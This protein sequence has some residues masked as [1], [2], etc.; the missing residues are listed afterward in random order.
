MAAVI[1]HGWPASGCGDDG[2]ARTFGG[3]GLR[4]RRLVWL[5]SWVLWEGH[6][7]SAEY[8]VWCVVR[9]VGG[10]WAVATAVGVEARGRCRY[11]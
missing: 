9:F 11:E 2:G 5:L 10:F 6:L 3:G 7:L 4:G 8:G 1:M